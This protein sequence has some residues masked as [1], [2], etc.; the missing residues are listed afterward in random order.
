MAPSRPRSLKYPCML[1]RCSHGAGGTQGR[2]VRAS[3]KG[4][5]Q[6]SIITS[7]PRPARRPGVRG[8]TQITSRCGS[9]WQVVTDT[10]SGI[11]GGLPLAL[12]VL[13][14]SCTAKGHYYVAVLP[15]CGASYDLP[16]DVYAGGPAVFIV[17]HP[18]ADSG[19]KYPVRRGVCSITFKGAGA[20][21]AGYQFRFQ[22]VWTDAVG[23]TYYDY[24]QVDAGGNPWSYG[25]RA[26]GPAGGAGFSASPWAVWRGGYRDYLDGVFTSP[27]TDV[28][29]V[30]FRQDSNNNKLATHSRYGFKIAVCYDGY[31]MTWCGGYLFTNQQLAARKP[32]Q[33]C[34]HHRMHLQLPRPGPGWG[35]GMTGA[36]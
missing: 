19:E 10:A 12:A 3:A 9:V 25:D 1:C 14:L 16:L 7:C 17:S 11:F 20:S 22:W 28:V 5:T 33:R 27:S 36:A 2:P 15:A 8:R 26:R 24:V 23:S 34:G 32:H 13:L 30:A 29:F 35:R 21:R 4:E 6:A 18:T 31:R